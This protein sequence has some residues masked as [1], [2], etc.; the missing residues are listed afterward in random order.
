MGQIFISGKEKFRE[1]VS[2]KDSVFLSATRN[3]RFNLIYN[4]KK[5]H[6]RTTATH[7]SIK[8]VSPNFVFKIFF[9]FF[10]LNKHLVVL[11]TFEIMP[12]CL[13][14]LDNILRTILEDKCAVQLSGK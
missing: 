5:K 6:T 3:D 7:N 11:L 10:L 1:R 12:G 13:F 9:F 2:E 14:Q 8:I 4:S